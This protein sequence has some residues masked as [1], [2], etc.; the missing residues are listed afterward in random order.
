MKSGKKLW[1][2]FAMVT[3]ISFAVLIY[4]GFEIFNKRHLSQK[5]L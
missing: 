4:Y 5:E 3:G 2:A 1:I